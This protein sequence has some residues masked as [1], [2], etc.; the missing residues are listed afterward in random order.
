MRLTYQ[1]TS[2]SWRAYVGYRYLKFVVKL[3]FKFYAVMLFFN[4]G[5]LLV[6]WI[7]FKDQFLYS[8]I[9]IYVLILSENLHIWSTLAMIGWILCQSGTSAPLQEGI[10]YVKF[11]SSS[12]TRN[13][14]VHFTLYSGIFLDWIWNLHFH[15]ILW[16]ERRI[17]EAN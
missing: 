2:Q 5:E 16:H 7:I 14:N 15:H 6:F 9:L 11:H 3:S 8:K 12:P 10:K 13:R 4:F 1:L 17:R